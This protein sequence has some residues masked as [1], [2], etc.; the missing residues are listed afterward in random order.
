MQLYKVTL[1]LLAIAALTN[2]DTI[3]LKSGNT[4]SH[5]ADPIRKPHA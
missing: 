5:S 1:S 2:A 3:Q 4:F